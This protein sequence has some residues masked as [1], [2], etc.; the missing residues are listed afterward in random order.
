MRKRA[1][2]I[3][4][5]IV[6]HNRTLTI[7]SRKSCVKAIYCSRP[8]TDILRLKTCGDCQNKEILLILMNFD[9][10]HRIGSTIFW[11]S[12]N[13]DR[14]REFRTIHQALMS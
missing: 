9:N 3:E 13:Q 5:L 7:G 6:P 2:P 4:K 10:N 14:Y 8:N 12:N 11:I 1:K